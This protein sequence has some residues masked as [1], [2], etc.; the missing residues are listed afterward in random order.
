MDDVIFQEFK[1]TANME[2]VL[3]RQLAER[4]I[5]PAIDLP[6]SAR[7]RKSGSWTGVYKQV[8]AAAAQPG[9][10]QPGRGDGGARQ[11]ARQRTSPMPNFLA[12]VKHLRTLK[13]KT[14]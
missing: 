12:R 13:P 5:Y 4:R 2:L 3:N 9:A 11:A 6:P 10:A 8:D 14:L 1:G 7:A